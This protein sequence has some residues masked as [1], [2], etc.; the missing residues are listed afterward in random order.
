MAGRVASPARTVAIVPARFAS[1]RFPGKPLADIAGVPM[2]IRVMRGITGSVDRAV[3]ATDDK[4]IAEV[5]E[6]AGFQAVMTGDACS[7]TERVFMAWNELGRPGETVINVQGDEPLVTGSWLK[8][9]ILD[10][11]G[12]DKV[13]TLARRVPSAQAASPGSVKVAVAGNG[14]ALY[15]SRYPVPHGSDQVLEHIGIY[16]FSPRSL[17]RCVSCGTTELSQTERLEQL[18]WIESGIRLKVMVGDFPGIGVDT[19]ED[20]EKAVVHFKT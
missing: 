15:F 9:L 16:A 6:G 13:L 11:P 10:P 19:P 2:V 3:V 8:P 20:L 18:A 17:V 5:V 1:T 14:D 7:G 12:G 4:R